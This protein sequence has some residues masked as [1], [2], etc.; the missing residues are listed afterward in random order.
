MGVL[1]TVGGG[2]PVCLFTP[3]KTKKE[4]DWSFFNGTGA[5]IDLQ[6]S[7][8]GCC[9]AINLLSSGFRWLR[10]RVVLQ[11]EELLP[12][13]Q[14][15]TVSDE[16]PKD[17]RFPETRRTSR[18]CKERLP[19]SAQWKHTSNVG[20]LQRPRSLH[21]AVNNELPP[22]QFEGEELLSTLSRRG[23]RAAVSDEAQLD[24]LKPRQAAAQP[25]S[26]GGSDGGGGN[27]D[28]FR[29]PSD[30]RP[31]KTQ[32]RACL[33]LVFC[34]HSVGRFPLLE[35]L[36]AAQHSSYKYLQVTENQVALL[37]SS[38]ST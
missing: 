12:P 18:F 17:Q 22:F 7:G 6:G 35:G 25:A 9:G 2:L 15:L 16:Q 14:K 4:V 3:H 8:P 27:L 5:A 34:S 10:G 11:R 30:P 21:Q 37:K 28:P 36:Q 33:P 31:D 20:M 38:G 32:E 23:P 26:S 24:L 13:A 19:V 29:R 1:G